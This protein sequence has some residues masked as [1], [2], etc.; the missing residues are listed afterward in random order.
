MKS[1][2]V[3]LGTAYFPCIEYMALMAVNSS[4]NIEIHETWPRQTFRNRCCI[5]TANGI[6]DLSVPV[7][8]PFGNHTLTSQVI[9]SNPLSWQ[10]QHLRSIESAY[11]NAP[12]FIYY[13][14]EFEFVF[15][16]KHESLLQLNQAILKQLIRILKLPTEILFSETFEKPADSLQDFRQLLSPKNKVQWKPENFIHTPYYQTFAD[17]HGFVGNLSIIDLLFNEGPHSKDYLIDTAER[18]FQ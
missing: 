18:L 14:P 15:T 13:F 11:Q 12:Y 9:I 6:L 10:K 2:P 3:L 5:M 7:S 4:I 17:R 16:Q 8:K 1:K